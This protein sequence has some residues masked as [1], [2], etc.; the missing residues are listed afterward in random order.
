MT[1]ADLSPAMPH[2]CPADPKFLHDTVETYYRDRLDRTWGFDHPM[3]GA[4]PGPNAIGLRSNDYLCLAG[5]ARVIEAEVAA[6]RRAG[7]GLS[8]SRIWLHH[9]QDPLNVFERRVAT[10]MGAQAAVLANSGYCANVGLIQA[11]A[12]PET[13]VYIDMKAHLSLWEGIKAAGA[14]PVPFR[15]NDFHHLDRLMRRDGPGVVVVDAVYSIDGN[16]CPLS[17]VVSVSEQHGGAIVLDETHSFGVRGRDGGGLAVE[18]GL[19]G[20]IHFRTIGLSKAVSSRGG[21]V[22]CSERNAEF[23]RYE[24]LP[25]IFS[26]QVLAH[27]IAGYNAI[28]DIFQSDPWRREQVHANH[29]YLATAL[30]ALGYNVSASKSQIIALEAGEIR[31]TVALRKALEARGVFGALFF[32]PATPEKRCLIRFTAHC[33]LTRT[34]LDRVIAV[35]A[36]IRDEVGLANWPSTRRKLRSSAASPAI[37]EAA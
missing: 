13:P 4:T 3:K 16:V 19:A 14:K 21:I 10:L 2:N 30:D 8:V 11:V 7:H 24:S 27:E 15:H 33:Q 9:E 6:L 32:P 25:V 20:R 22:V 28:L 18:L 34:E 29:R 36:E 5:D 23:L 37:A 26:T 1:I 12:R 31:A 17:D 35:C